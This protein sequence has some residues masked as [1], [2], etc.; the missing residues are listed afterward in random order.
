MSA[1]LDG[2][3][4]AHD[5]NRY[6]NFRTYTTT[7]PCQFTS[8]AVDP[9]GEVLVAGTMDPFHIYTWN[10]Q[11]GKLLDIFTGHVGPIS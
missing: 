6:R 7:Q 11:S 1:S 5:L 3:V 10:V 4:R 8:L 9:S 2:T